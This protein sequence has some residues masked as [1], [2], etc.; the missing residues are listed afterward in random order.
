[1]LLPRPVA[2]STASEDY[3]PLAA[4]VQYSNDAIVGFDLKS[5]VKNWNAGAE[6]LFGYTREEIVGRSIETFVPDERRK[7]LHELLA[8]VMKGGSVEAYETVRQRK[9]GSLIDVSVTL[10]P[11]RDEHGEIIWLSG[12]IRNIGERKLIDRQIE[13][14]AQMLAQVSDALISTDLDHHITYW[15]KAAEKLL[16]YTEAEVLGKVKSEVLQFSEGA[17]DEIRFFNVLK[18]GGAWTGERVAYAKDGRKL[19]VE[20]G[21]KVLKDK[22]G[23]PL[24][25][26]IVLHDFTDRRKAEEQLKQNAEELARSNEQLVQFAYVASHDLKEPLRMVTHFVQLIEKKYKGRLDTDA[27][28]YIGYAVDGATRMYE[29]INDLLIYSRVGNANRKLLVEIDCNS[30]LDRVINNLQVSIKESQAVIERTPLPTL[31]ADPTQLAQLFQNLISNAIKFKGAESPV[32]RIQ[33]LKKA[34]EWQFSVN[35]NGI[36]IDSKFSERIF[37]I[38]QRLHSRADY[39]GTGIGLAICKK[40]VEGHGG[41]IWVDSVLGQGARFS[42]SLPEPEVTHVPQSKAQ[43]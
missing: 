14:H 30:V 38:F 19:D 33:T 1:M 24:G 27:D 10:S 6:K 28:E 22:D 13:L 7:E 42:F 32:V 2:N 5:Q 16:G 36:G 41:K 9:D 35:D 37:V 43:A 3:G 4:I 23:G 39:P 40:I 11:V 17:D 15:N 29:L 21:V 18:A 31:Y 20:L 8:T 34:H 12:I 26:L 25:L